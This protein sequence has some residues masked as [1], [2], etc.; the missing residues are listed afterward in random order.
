VELSAGGGIER[1]AVVKAEGPL[2]CCQGADSKTI[3]MPLSWRLS[4]TELP[5]KRWPTTDRPLRSGEAEIVGKQDRRRPSGT[6]PN[7]RQSRRTT[8]SSSSYLQGRDTSQMKCV[9]SASQQFRMVIADDWEWSCVGRSHVGHEPWR[10][11]CERGPVQS[12]PSMPSPDCSA[13]S[14]RSQRSRS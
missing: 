5:R 3:L 4:A 13:A 1:G 2:V 10:G 9:L 6:S 14:S 11:R 12:R 7:N 8:Q